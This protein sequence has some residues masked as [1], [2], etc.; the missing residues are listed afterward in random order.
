MNDKFIKECRNGNLTEVKRLLKDPRVDPSTDDNYAIRHTSVYG[1]I[2]IV[3]LL[4]K[5][6]RADPSA[7]DNLSI[8][9]ASYE[10]HTEIVRLLLKDPRVDPSTGGNYAIRFAS[11]EGHL[12]IVRLLLK[13]P[14]VDPSADDNYAIRFASGEGH[15][16]IFELLLKD[17]R[18]DIYKLQEQIKQEEY[19]RLFHI[20]KGRIKLIN[21]SATII[22]RG[23][24]NWLWKPKC[25]DGTV[26]IQCRMMVKEL[27]GLQ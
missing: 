7:Y 10:G 8:R 3:S 18:I 16:E 19:P 5:D 20:I 1:H 9:W 26:G 15:L 13:D 6:P 22:Q 14:R 2:E 12:E 11:G 25:D 27:E 23:C 21:N 4:L 17:S 24:H